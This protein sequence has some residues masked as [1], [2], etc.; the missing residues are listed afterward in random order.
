[1][2][3]AAAILEDIFSDNHKPVRKIGHGMFEPGRAISFPTS[4][5]ATGIVRARSL[6]MADGLLHLDTDPNV[7]QVSP[8]PMEIGYWSTLDEKTPAKRDHIPDVAIQLRDESVVFIDYVTVRG[9]NDTPFFWRRR[10]ERVR[11][12]RDQLGCTYAVHDERSIRIQP[13]LSNLRLMWSHRQRPTE[14]PSLSL[15]REALRRTKLP[16]TI[17]AISDNAAFS[18]QAIRWAEDE[19]PVLLEETNLI[20]TAVMQMAMRGEVRLDLGKRLTLDSTVYEVTT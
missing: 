14:P 2:T 18:R 7:I 12:F 10:A 13:R 16:T 19:V 3:D 1:V 9:Q 17:R 15:A 6:L 8:Y 5:V 4:K 11:H 20:F